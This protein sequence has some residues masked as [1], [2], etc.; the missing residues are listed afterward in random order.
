MKLSPAAPNNPK[1]HAIP[2]D[3][4]NTFQY[5]RDAQNNVLKG[6]IPSESNLHFAK[7]SGFDENG[8]RTWVLLR[9]SSYPD[10]T[11]MPLAEAS[12]FFANEIRTSLLKLVK[13]K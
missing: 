13:R 12:E 6:Y 5:Y 2:P 1:P 10:L 9:S 11:P 8:N 4:P 7:Y 3:D